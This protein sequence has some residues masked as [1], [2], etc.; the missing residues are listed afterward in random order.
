VG[1]ASNRK[2]AL[3]RPGR[4]SRLLFPNDPWCLLPLNQR[5]FQAIR[6]SHP[7]HAARPPVRSYGFKTSTDPARNSPGCRENYQVGRPGEFGRLAGLLIPFLVGRDRK[8]GR[9][10]V[11][12]AL[13]VPP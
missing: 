7:I 8:P 13:H 6:S 1:R 11:P 10:R 12:P 9:H 2:K 4:E 5:R 3:R